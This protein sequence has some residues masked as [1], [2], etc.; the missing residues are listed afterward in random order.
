MLKELCFLLQLTSLC[1]KLDSVWEEN[2]G[3]V[4]LFMWMNFLQDEAFTY[5]DLQSPLDLSSVLSRKRRL[6]GRGSVP[7]GSTGGSDEGNLTTSGKPSDS[8]Q[9]WD[10]R[11]IQDIASQDRLLPTIL[12]YDKHEKRRQF[13]KECFSCEVCFLEKLGAHCIMFVGCGHVYC[14]DCMRDYFTVQI[15]DGNVNGLMCPAD[16]CESQAHP[17]QVRLFIDYF[18]LYSFI[19]DV[20]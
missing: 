14:K 11:A 20:I 13:E 9:T 3:M 19:I 1:Q 15:K 17:A 16:R 4:I 18:I 12:D 8:V 10:S 6:S 5:L 2:K 7:R